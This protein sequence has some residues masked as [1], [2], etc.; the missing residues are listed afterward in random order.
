VDRRFADAL[1]EHH[2]THHDQEAEDQQQ[3]QLDRAAGGSDTTQPEV[4]CP[5]LDDRHGQARNPQLY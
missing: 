3:E 5:G 1:R 4:A 2:G